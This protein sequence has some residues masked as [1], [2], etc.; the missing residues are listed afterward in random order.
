QGREQRAATPAAVLP[1]I[2]PDPA[3]RHLPFPLTDVQ[4]AYLIGR[5]DAFALGQVST[6]AYAEVDARGIDLA[7]L[8]HAYRTLIARHDMLRAVV[9]PDGRQEILRE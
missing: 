3:R 1:E 8:T 9:H 4:Q 7:R 5:G 6:H 2:V